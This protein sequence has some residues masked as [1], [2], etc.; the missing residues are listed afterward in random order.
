MAL[1]AWAAHAY[2]A[3]GLPLAA[4]MA[5]LIVRGRPE[6]LRWAFVL[7]V[8]ACVVDATDGRLARRMDVKH[9]IPSFDGRR[10][11][12][13]I[14]FQTYT[15][16]PLLLLWRARVLPEGWS[17]LL[18]LP[19]VASAYGFCQEQAKTDDG[20][21]L[22]FP[23]YWNI[24][25]FYLY[26][27]PMP[28][29]AAAAILVVFSLLTFVP[30]RYLYPSQEG[31][32]LNRWACGLGGAWAAVILWLVIAPPGGDLFGVPARVVTGLSLA[33]PLFYL[34]ASWW[35]EAKIRLQGLKGAA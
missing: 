24:V 3:L 22:G 30:T 26:A 17:W 32:A 2:T 6:D 27:W 8:L 23:S 19:L 16:L 33:Y 9:R 1:W 7:M 15:S 28:A 10:L 5:V 34:V 13:I 12:D 18:L 31:G 25:A 14:D 35:V 21:F 29:W 4:G 20:Y 11:D